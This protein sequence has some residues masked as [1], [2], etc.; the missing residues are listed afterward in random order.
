LNRHERDSLVYYTFPALERYGELVHAV[1]TRHGGV[2]SGPYSSLNL[3]RAVGDAPEAVEEN[4]RRVAGA[5]GL[6]RED[7][8]SPTQR[9]TANVQRVGH[10]DRG[11]ICESCDTLLTD[12]PGV[13]VLLRFAD[14]TPIL[15]Y[16]PAHRAFALVHSGWR[17]TVQAAARAAVEALEQSFGS[18]PADLVAAV[19]PSI[20]PCCYEVGDEV[21]GAVRAAFDDADGLLPVVTNGR[22][23]FDLWAANR[24][25]LE[26]A[27]VGT[28]E[29]AG[30]CTACRVD[31]FY[32]HRRERGKT[33][34]F[35]AVMCLS[36]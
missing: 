14:C 16:D 36:A 10:G 9:H 3:T 23:H 29:V 19:G 35:G 6:R 28:V 13:P 31:D 15:I 2:S 21:T 30:L 26:Q 1:T 24:R 27:G 34:H 7:L 4:L 25:W 12:T 17:G 11:S 5:L 20:G 22:H 33:G 18:R 32:S 8:V